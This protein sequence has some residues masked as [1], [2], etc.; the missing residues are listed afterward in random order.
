M[1]S[2]H[3]HIFQLART[4][5]LGIKQI[6]LCS[7]F[8]CKGNTCVWHRTAICIGSTRTCHVVRRAG[9]RA[10]NSAC[11]SICTNGFYFNEKR[12]RPTYLAMDKR[13]TT[14]LCLACKYLA[15]GNFHIVPRDRSCSHLGKEL[16]GILPHSL[17]QLLL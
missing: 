16:L 9:Y 17:L 12:L 13:F 10:C 2:S 4:F 1:L 3:R 14:H 15:L 5:T 11:S 8:T 7:L 6:I